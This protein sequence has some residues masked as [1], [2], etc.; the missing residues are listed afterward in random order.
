MNS[1]HQY[2]LESGR[3]GCDWRSERMSAGD[4]VSYLK[5]INFLQPTRIKRAAN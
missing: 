4:T 1:R 2:N 3:L 5:P